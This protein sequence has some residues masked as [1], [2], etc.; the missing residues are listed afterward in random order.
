[1]QKYLINHPQWLAQDRPHIESFFLKANAPDSAQAVWLKVTCLKQANATGGMDEW[2]DLWGCIFHQKD[3]EYHGLRQRFR[4]DEFKVEND[5]L[6]IETEAVRIFFGREKGHFQTRLQNKGLAM[7]IAITWQACASPH[8]A[9]YSTLPYAWMLNGRL[10]KQKTVTPIG[11]CLVN[12]TVEMDKCKLELT[13]WTGCQG[14]NWGKAHTPD[15]VWVHSILREHGQVVGTCEAFSG[16][17]KVGPWRVGPFSGAYL[18][19]GEQVYAFD[20][21]IDTWNHES[22]FENGQ[23][24]LTLKQGKTQLKLKATA[25][26]DQALCLGYEDPDGGMN[27]CMNSKLSSATIILETPNATRSFECKE[28]V[29][30]E[31]L[32]QKPGEHVI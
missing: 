15:Y 18:R 28:N 27:Y 32:E 12:G 30:L 1:M 26:L 7:D 14:H 5:V 9:D 19:I 13:Q 31:W 22:S 10:P 24:L 6:S 2:I 21:L 25:A 8:G 23:F 3:K 11:L 20:R 29:A 17:V 16:K 4:L